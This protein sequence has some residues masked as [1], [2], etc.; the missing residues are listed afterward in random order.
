MTRLPYFDAMRAYAVILGIVIHAASGYLVHSTPIWPHLPQSSIMFDCMVWV[1]HMF[2]VPVFFFVAGFFT[3]DLWNRKAVWGFIQNRWKRIVVPFL[4]SAIIFNIPTIL[5]NIFFHKLKTIH[6]FLIICS[7]LGFT[8]FLEYLL[9]FYLLFLIINPI[10]KRSMFKKIANIIIA[11]HFYV[12]IFVF[13]TFLMLWLNKSVY[14]PISLS[15]IPNFWLLLF[16]GLYFFLGVLVSHD[17]E[18]VAKLFDWRW[19]YLFICFVLLVLNVTIMYRW[20]AKGI[21]LAIFLYSGASFL[22]FYCFIA[23]CIKFCHRQ[24]RILQYI[25]D[26]SYWIYLTQVYLILQLQTLFSEYGWIYFKFSVTCIITLL[27]GLFSYDLFFRKGKI[28]DITDNNNPFN[29]G[30][31]IIST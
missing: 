13:V 9:I 21:T 10:F 15:Y 20:P 2:R 4:M 27:V 12:V 26:A 31:I 28:S 3:Y 24:N 18:S 22:L 14:I 30:V 23:A 5:T 11:K 6:D 29:K 25:S 16:Y 8:W 19:N 17:S 1:I 7:N